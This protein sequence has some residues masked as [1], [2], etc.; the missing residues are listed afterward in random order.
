MFLADQ[1]ISFSARVSIVLVV[2]L[3][4][5]GE[6]HV[7]DMFFVLFHGK[8]TMRFLI[9]NYLK[10]KITIFKRKFACFKLIHQVWF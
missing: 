4:F 9:N 7:L 8:Y 1:M 3:D 6:S 10:P 2:L 5:L